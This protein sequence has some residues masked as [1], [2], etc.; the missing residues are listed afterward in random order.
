MTKQPLGVLVIHG[1]TSSLD[2]VCSVEA[3]VRELGIPT[4]MPVLRGHGATSPEALR[5]VRWPD[6]V[7]DGQAALDDLLTEVDRAVLFG[8]SM[9]GLVALTLAA[10][11]GDRI[12]SVVAAAA[13]VQLANPIAPGRPLSFLL[14]A[15]RRLLKSW[16]MPPKYVDQSAAPTDTNYRY[17]PIPAV[18]SFL[19]FSGATRRRL[20]EVRAPILILQSRK[21][22]TV[23]PESAEIIYREVSTPA[24]Q[25]RIVW[26]EATE[27]EMFR[28]CEREATTRAVAEY[29]QER[30]GRAAGQRG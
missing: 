27:H 26:F 29:V 10:E 8:H 9:G 3:A 1:F 30:A 2:C 18:T 25:K 17:A 28:D 5:P 12:D 11:N 13:A 7:A 22:T 4:R 24:D 15:V 23:A 14:P 6:W 16:P 19:E 21:D 20:P